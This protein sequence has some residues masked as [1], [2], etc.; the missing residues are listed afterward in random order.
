MMIAEA[1][2]SARTIAA[3]ELRQAGFCVVEAANAHEAITYLNA[4][5]PVDLVF[6]MVELGSS[7]ED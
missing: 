1:E 6:K 7:A 2:V 3:D 5:T 4:G